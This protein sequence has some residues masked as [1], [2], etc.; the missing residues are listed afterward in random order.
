MGTSTTNPKVIALLLAVVAF[1]LFYFLI[2]VR[3]QDETVK[4]SAYADTLQQEVTQLQYLESEID[5]YEKEI[6]EATK[7]IN[8]QMR[9]LPSGMKE[10][11]Y[12][13]WM[14]EFERETGYDF[15]TISI[16]EPAAFQEVVTAIDREGEYYEV[17]MNTYA[18]TT[19]TNSQLSYGMVKDVLDYIY[20][21]PTV[22]LVDSVD[23]VYSGEN[24]Q[25]DLDTTF[26]I[27]RVFAEHE[28]TEYEPVELPEFDLGVPN[29]FGSY[30]VTPSDSGQT[31][32]GGINDSITGGA[33]TTSPN[34][35]GDGEYQGK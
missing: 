10:E 19:T 30:T 12:L 34:V 27:T 18:Y 32:T 13:M 16:S 8:Q 1:V 26:T 4:V 35:E 29:P 17:L 14:L 3:I 9:R 15:D 23:I 25:K 11:D 28:Y 33:T 20:D 31:A 5:V 21:Y 2:Y 6:E 22:A 7:Y 24:P